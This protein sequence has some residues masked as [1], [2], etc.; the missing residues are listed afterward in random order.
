MQATL[1]IPY[2][3]TRLYQDSLEKDWLLTRDWNRYTMNECILKCPMSHEEV[4]EKI[5]D[6]YK[7]AVTPRY[8]LKKVLT[9][10]TR[11][12]LRFFYRGFKFWYGHLT[13]F[14]QFNSRRSA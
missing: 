7:A 12:D 3:G 4:L 14:G 2:P 5:R 1:L 6:C 10:R 11:D 8:I 9:V 13:D